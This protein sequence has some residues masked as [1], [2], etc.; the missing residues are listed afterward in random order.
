MKRKFHARFLGGRGRVN[1]LRLPRRSEASTMLSN[2]ETAREIE[3]TMR[4]CSA[5]LNESI[6]LVMETCTEEEFKAYRLTIGT[7][8]GDIYLNVVQP[9][10]RQYPD[11]EPPEMKR[12]DAPKS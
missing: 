3:G 12:Y 11:L 5:I 6:R 9:I 8:M 2:K 10:H 1:R 4:Q 7:I